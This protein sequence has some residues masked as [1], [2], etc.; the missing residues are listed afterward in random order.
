NSLSKLQIVLNRLLKPH[1]Q[2]KHISPV[3]PG[4]HARFDAKKRVYRYVIKKSLPTPFESPYCRYLPDLNRNRLLAALHLFE[5]EHDFIHFHKRGSD[6]NSTIRSIYKTGLYFFGNYTLATFEANGFLRAQVRM[7]MESAIL[8]MRG[9]LD[10]ESIK[11]QL[12]G[13]KLFTPP[14]AEPQALYLA[15]VIY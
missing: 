4:F 1:I 9:E 5:G 6:P 7:M 11:E 14:L 8:V 13:V 12:R 2:F 3:E 15:R 10:Q